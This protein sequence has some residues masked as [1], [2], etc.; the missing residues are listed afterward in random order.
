MGPGPRLSPAVAGCY[1]IEA[2]DYL[3]T[4]AA[5][6]GFRELPTVIAL[7]T[8]GF[9]RVLIPNA[10]RVADS[11]GVNSAGLSLY[12]HAWT[13]VGDWVRFDQR[14]RQHALGADSVIV[15]LRGWGGSMRLYLARDGDGFAGLGGFA[16]LMKPEDAP[17]IFVRLRPARCPNDLV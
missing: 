6:T 5:I 7:D 16:P 13:V 15:T 3:G 12:G 8:A 11:P 1:A 17:A 9:G 10:W 14:S 2:R 4:H